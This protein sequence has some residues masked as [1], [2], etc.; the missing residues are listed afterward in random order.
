MKKGL[1]T[2]L[3]SA[4]LL[5]GCDYVS[6]GA[7][8]IAEVQKNFTQLAHKEVKVMGTVQG[9]SQFPF[10]TS[11]VFIVQDGTGEILVVTEGELPASGEKITLKGTVETMATVG[12]QSLGL[13]IKETK[14]LNVLF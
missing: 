11:K 9:G 5:T 13:H 7:T 6:Y 3:M 1:M 4:A 2:L 12:Q 8:P 14:R 10:M